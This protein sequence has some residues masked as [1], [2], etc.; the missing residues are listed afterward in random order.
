MLDEGDHSHIAFGA[1]KR[2]GGPQAQMVS[3]K[4]GEVTEW[5]IVYVPQSSSGGGN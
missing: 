2:R 3:V 1:P 5:R 4:S